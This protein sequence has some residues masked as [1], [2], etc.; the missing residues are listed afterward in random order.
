[1]TQQAWDE[2]GNILFLG[3]A[4]LLFVLIIWAGERRNKAEAQAEKNDPD[5][6]R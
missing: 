4:L 6:D 5:E 1:M 3:V 2:L